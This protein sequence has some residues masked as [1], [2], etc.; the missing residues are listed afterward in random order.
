MRIS[1]LMNRMAT[2]DEVASMIA[3]LA[4]EEASYINGSVHVVDG[5]MTC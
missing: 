4:S 1:P 3:F 2:P 5:A